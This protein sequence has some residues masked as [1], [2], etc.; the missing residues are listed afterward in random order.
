LKIRERRPFALG[1]LILPLALRGQAGLQALEFKQGLIRLA[2]HEHTGRFS[3]DYLTDPVA[4]TYE[5]LFTHQDPRT[6]FL[7]VNLNGRVYRLGENPA[8]TITVEQNKAGPAVVFESPFL[9]VRQEFAFIKTA[10]SLESNGVKMTVRVENLASELARTGLR[11]LIDTN[12]GESSGENPFVTNTQVI[13]AETII[14]GASEDLFW[15]SRNSRL[16]LMGSVFA[17]AETKPDFLHFAN[18][19]RLNDLPWKIGYSQGRNFNYRP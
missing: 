12:L 7:A 10:G 18:W 16:S 4:E 1:V 2:I 6:S 13:A 8:F 14:S 17:G 15:I 19:K 5:P 9:R 11:V 3:L